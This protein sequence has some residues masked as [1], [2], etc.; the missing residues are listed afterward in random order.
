M[1]VDLT[2]RPT[3]ELCDCPGLRFLHWRRLLGPVARFVDALRDRRANP[4][5]AVFLRFQ[6]VGDD[7]GEKL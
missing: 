1:T 5:R 6:L 2:L 7:D 4:W 3:A